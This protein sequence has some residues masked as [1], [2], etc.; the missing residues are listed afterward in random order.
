VRTSMIVADPHIIKALSNMNAIVSLANGNM[1]QAILLPLLEDDQLLRLSREVICPFY[2]HR[3]DFAVSILQKELGES[4]PW[5][6]HSRD[7]AFF[8]WLWL[9]DLRIPAKELY[10][11]L[12]KEKV[13]VIPG[14][15]FAFGLP[16]PWDHA[17]QCLRLTYSQ[18]EHIVREG[19]EILGHVVRRVSHG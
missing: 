10:Q 3:S 5:S 12:K 19:L 16:Q 15:Y 8:L 17:D 14:H 7:G 11:Q 18:P 6:L 4:V 1:G 13:L 2:K 9:K